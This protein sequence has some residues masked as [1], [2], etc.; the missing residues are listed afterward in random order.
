MMKLELD[1]FYHTDIKKYETDKEKYDNI[2]DFIDKDSKLNLIL[3]YF[4]EY[5]IKDIINK[6]PTN[7]KENIKTEYFSKKGKIFNFN[8][9]TD[10]FFNKIIQY[11]ENRKKEYIKYIGKL[12]TY[13]N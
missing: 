3:N 12:Y 5:D 8:I 11:V 1:A 2:K 9:D 7:V 6:I 10:K 4:K 13:F